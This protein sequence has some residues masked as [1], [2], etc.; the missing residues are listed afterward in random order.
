MRQNTSHDSVAALSYV[1]VSV[2]SAHVEASVKVCMRTG[3]IYS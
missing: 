3:G 1:V 2:S